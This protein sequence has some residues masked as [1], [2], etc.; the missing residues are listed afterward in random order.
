MNYDEAIIDHDAEKGALAILINAESHHNKLNK[1][2]PSLFVDERNK[3][4][5]SV[6]KS[7]FRKGEPINEIT[8]SQY[9]KRSKVKEENA[10]GIEYLIKVSNNFTSEHNFDY[11]LQILNENLKRREVFELGKKAQEL[12]KDK[13]YEASNLSD[14]FSVIC[15]RLFKQSAPKRDWFKFLSPSDCRSFTPNEGHVLVGDCHIV[16]GSTTVLSGAP[17]TGKSRA[18][19]YL[20]VAGAKGDNWFGLPVHSKFKTAILQGENGPYRLKTELEQLTDES[21]DKYIRISE[22]PPSGMAFRDMEFRDALRHYLADFNPDLLILDPW[23]GITGDDSQRDYRE[24]LNNIRD[25]IPKGDKEPA[26]LIVAHN[27][28]PKSDERRSGRALLNEISGSHVLSSAARCAFIMQAATDDE[29]DN[30]VVW[31]CAKNNDG[32]LPAKS[33]WYRKNGI[34]LPCLDF[35]WDDFNKGGNENSKPI[36]IDDLRKLFDSGKRRLEKNKAVDELMEITGKGKSSCYNALKVESGK[37]S[38]FLVEKD[39]LIEWIEN[40]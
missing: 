12:A 6:I 35:D 16:R 24:A 40:D 29:E 34:F 4:L 33:A 38:E 30:R 15:K 2:S 21:F 1:L 39:Y 18:A 13:S 36:S 28:K 9:L 17:G 31:S 3:M 23:N 7:L 25:A 37:Y 14:E 32:T 27:R 19:T 26:I 20:A 8:L 11:W 22:P 10:G 5:L